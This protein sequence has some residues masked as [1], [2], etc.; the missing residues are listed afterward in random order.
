MLNEVR[1]G[2]ILGLQRAT[3]A[4]LHVLSV[5]LADLELV[6]SEI[7]VL[8]NL[9]AGPLSVGRL[10]SATATKPTTLTSVLDRLVRRGQ[11]VRELDQGDRR[12][13]RV[14]LT[15][16]GQAAADT[17]A[18][19]ITDLERQ[20]LAGVSEADLAGFR[21]VVHALTEVRP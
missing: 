16:A 6:P 17:I 9:A 3:H 2:I 21:A 19:A 7:N 5:R 18:A 10:A 15:T 1:D 11:V 12:S 13:F 8:A 20:A 14:S 4:T